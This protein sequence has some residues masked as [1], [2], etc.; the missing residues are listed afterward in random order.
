M[1]LNNYAFNFAFETP[2]GWG[3]S[4]KTEKNFKSRTGG[5]DL[6]EEVSHDSQAATKISRNVRKAIF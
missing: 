4:F 2:P 1:D 5:I 3:M 6:P